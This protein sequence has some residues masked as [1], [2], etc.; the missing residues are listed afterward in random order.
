MSLVGNVY[1]QFV[2]ATLRVAEDK[3]IIYYKIEDNV[4][5]VE[6]YSIYSTFGDH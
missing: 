3:D 4:D 1:K 5:A 2:F 6:H